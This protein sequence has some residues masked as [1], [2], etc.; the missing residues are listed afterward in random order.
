MCEDI[1]PN[2][3]RAQSLERN[4]QCSDELSFLFL[5]ISISPSG[6]GM[7]LRW[8]NTYKLIRLNREKSLNCAFISPLRLIQSL[9]LHRFF[10]LS[11][12]PSPGKSKSCV[13]LCYTYTAACDFHLENIYASFYCFYG[14]H[15]VHISEQI[16]RSFNILFIKLWQAM[17]VLQTHHFSCDEGSDNNEED[18]KGSE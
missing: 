8:Q 17:A 15:H 12:S 1:I 10:I 6:F 18:A 3:R 7:D 14:A 16:F 13:R 11:L 4:F 5:A 2:L 9:I